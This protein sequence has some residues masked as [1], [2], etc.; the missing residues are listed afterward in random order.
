MRC[1]FNYEL[2]A[3]YEKKKLYRSIFPTDVIYGTAI[4][5][6]AHTLIRFNNLTINQLPKITNIKKPVADRR[7]STTFDL[8]ER[9]GSVGL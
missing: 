8:S 7:G 5:I 3:S 6:K 2:A 1:F 4:S 9:K